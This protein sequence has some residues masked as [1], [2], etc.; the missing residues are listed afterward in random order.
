VAEPQ[1]PQ[2]LEQAATSDRRLLARSSVTLISRSFSKFAQI[3]FLVL[4]ARLLSVE[5]FASYS[6]LLVLAAAF[7]ILSDTGVPLVASRDAS[8][9][10]AS[11]GDLFFSALPVVIVSAVLAALVL[12]VVGAVDSGP[13]STFVPVLVTAAYVLFNRLF[14]FT[15]T[16]LRGVGRFTFEALLQSA[17][18]VFFIVGASMAVVA[19]LGVTAVLAILA[20]K[21][22][23]SGLIAYAAIRGDLERPA[24]APRRSDWRGLFKIGIKLAVA[25]VAVALLMRIPLAVLGNV[26][27]DR[28]VALFSAAQR[29]G[30]AIYIL[31]ISSGFALMPGI[32]YLA[33]ADPERARRLVHRVMFAVI[34]ASGV[35]AAAAL[36]FAEPIM[37]AIFGG[38]FVS[39]ANLLRI[40]LIGIPGSATLGVCWYVV[41]AFDGEARL[42]GIGLLGL[43]LSALLSAILIPSAGDEGAAWAYVGSLYAM[44]ALTVF[45]LERQLGRT[46]TRPAPSEADV[47]VSALG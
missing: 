28:E 6:Y 8:A 44:A 1:A 10:R 39:G 4:A 13:G 42:V 15:A 40:V 36:P 46:A 25:G 21:E 16:M 18:A 41:V 19:D 3:L 7:T 11:P 47:P 35:L 37:R 5:E 22:L 17:G 20:T 27:S 14:D 43:A 30:D 32:S 9:G 2:R 33:R 23:V 38:D 26:G 45:V 24:G 31:A 29:F 12:P 34:A